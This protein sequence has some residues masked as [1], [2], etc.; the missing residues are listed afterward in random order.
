M[1]LKVIQF[2]GLLVNYKSSL[3][4]QQ[5]LVAQKLLNRHNEPDYLLLLEHEPIITLG[6]RCKIEVELEAGSIRGSHPIIKVNSLIY[7]HFIQMFSFSRLFLSSQI[8]AVG[9]LIMD[10]AN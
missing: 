4:L 3:E 8:E 9:S 1:S 7:M 6:R 5:K 10:Q 2:P